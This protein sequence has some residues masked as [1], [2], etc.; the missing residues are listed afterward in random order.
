[1]SAIANRSPREA[2]GLRPSAF[3]AKAAYLIHRAKVQLSP[4]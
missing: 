4:G 3:P 2:H 1:L